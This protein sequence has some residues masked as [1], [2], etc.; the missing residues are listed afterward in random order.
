M[1]RALDRGGQLS[2]M[3]GAVPRDS[4]GKDLAALGDISLQLIDIL[5]VDLIV[6]AAEHA[7]FLSSVESAFSSETA[8]T[9]C[10]LKCHDFD[11]L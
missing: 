10:S 2:L 9:I 6:L 3:L 1:T 8:F 5:V 11:L 7:D 4:S